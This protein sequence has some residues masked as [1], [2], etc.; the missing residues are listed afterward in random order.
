MIMPLE[1][2]ED[3]RTR[4]KGKAMTAE[5]ILIVENDESL[6]EVLDQSLRYAGY[7]VRR[8]Q[9]GLGALCLPF[10]YKVDL[11]LLGRDLACEDGG[12]VTRRLR[13]GNR[14]YYLPILLLIPREEI[15][16][17]ESVDLGGAD[18]YVA[19]PA[20]LDEIISKVRA[21]LEDRKAH[22]RARELLCA[23]I[24]EDVEGML[25]EVIQKT[26][27]GRADEMLGRLSEGL[28][29]LLEQKAREGLEGK[30]EQLASEEFARR[31][32]EIVRASAETVVDEVANEV[33]TRI[34]SDAVEDKSEAMMGRLEREELPALVQRV[35]E[36]SLRALQPEIVQRVQQEARKML[37]EDITA[38]LPKL[39]KDM[40]ARALPGAASEQLPKILGDRIQEGVDA[41]LARQLP[42]RMENEVVGKMRQLARK[43]LK[44]YFLLWISIAVAVLIAASGV[45]TW[46][47]KTRN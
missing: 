2:E 38:N 46:I 1:R 20:D 40:V 21:V 8:A 33:V 18:G 4:E 45:I 3:R 34:S 47:V 26:F 19:V 6:I 42:K 24:N 13:R 43:E 12:E 32:D 14:T 9:N 28:V 25:N 39:V 27:Q 22:D 5:T 31:V 36:E 30:V 23:R 44:R 37:V 11:I 10:E 17:E 29:D 35:A 41:E 16:K 15:S 7:S